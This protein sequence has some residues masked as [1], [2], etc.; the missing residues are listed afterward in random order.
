MG[1]WF[2]TSQRDFFFVCDQPTPGWPFDPVRTRKFFAGIVVRPQ[3]T[4]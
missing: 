1:A 4:W 2:Y 3:K